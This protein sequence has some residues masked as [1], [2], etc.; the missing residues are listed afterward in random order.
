MKT[1]KRKEEEQN[2]ICSL[3]NLTDFCLRECVGPGEGHLL[4]EAD[5]CFHSCAR[6][7]ILMR[8]RSRDKWME[9][10]SRTEHE[11]SQAWKSFRG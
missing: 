5:Q 2:L 4:K 10:Y 3:S 9:D 8:F 11:N 7:L 1:T 6:N